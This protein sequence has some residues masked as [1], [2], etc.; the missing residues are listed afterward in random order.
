M[1][2]KICIISKEIKKCQGI[3]CVFAYSNLYVSD[4]LTLSPHHFLWL[5]Y[6]TMWFWI[7]V[8]VKIAVFKFLASY[9][10]RL[11]KLNV[12]GCKKLRMKC[13]PSAFFHSRLLAWVLE[14]PRVLPWVSFSVYLQTFVLPLRS[15]K[16]LGIKV[17]WCIW[18]GQVKNDSIV[19]HCGKGEWK[20]PKELSS[21]PKE[22]GFQKMFKDLYF[23]KNV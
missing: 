5:S 15:L 22:W 13:D 20:L 6:T 19:L 18:S 11:L 2:Q 23:K 14:W 3:Q 12:R 17:M 9:M 8:T 7:L 1:K 16:F 4:H 10:H 21:T